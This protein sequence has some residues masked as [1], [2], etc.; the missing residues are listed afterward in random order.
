MACGCPIISTD[1]KYGP[2]EILGDN[3]YGIL[4][5]PLD[6]NMH[7][8][9]EPLSTNEKYLCAAMMNLLDDNEL[10]VHYAQKSKERSNYFSTDN[11]IGEYEKLFKE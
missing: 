10:R 8:A 5:P 1:C 4:V 3:K 2:R 6:G 9:S 7:S 11:C